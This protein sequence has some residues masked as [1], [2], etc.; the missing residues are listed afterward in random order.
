M[1]PQVQV[2]KDC[3]QQVLGGG[4]EFFVNSSCKQNE[5]KKISSFQDFKVMSFCDGFVPG[6]R[7]KIFFDRFFLFLEIASLKSMLSY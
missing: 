3:G 5:K 1:L 2:G 6:A 7:P 4:E